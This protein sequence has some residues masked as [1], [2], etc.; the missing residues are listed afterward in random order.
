MYVNKRFTAFRRERQ[1]FPETG[2]LETTVLSNS[3][4]KKRERTSFDWVRTPKPKQRWRQQ[5]EGEVTTNST[6]NQ[7]E[8]GRNCTPVV[9]REER[10][11]STE[12][13]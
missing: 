6:K 10:T 9:S 1:Q 3:S 4:P 13:W 2:G 7:K 12:R 11:V 8:R 5:H